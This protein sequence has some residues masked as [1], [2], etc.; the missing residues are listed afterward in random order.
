MCFQWNFCKCKMKIKKMPAHD[1]SCIPPRLYLPSRKDFSCVK[2]AFQRDL[3]PWR[4]PLRDAWVRL[5]EWVNPFQKIKTR[6]RYFS[7]E[8]AVPVSAICSEE[9]PLGDSL[10]HFYRT[11]VTSIFPDRFGKCNWNPKFI[12]NILRKLAFVHFLSL[13]VLSCRD[14]L[15]PAG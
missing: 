13:I 6:W 8:L 9:L 7:V 12:T 2:S 11:R 5:E 3:F 15:D 4:F 14:T 10:L 1:P